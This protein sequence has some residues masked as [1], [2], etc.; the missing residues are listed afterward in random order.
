MAKVGIR[1]KKYSK[2][3]IQEALDLS[4]RSAANLLNKQDLRKKYFDKLE[5]RL[6]DTVIKEEKLESIR[7]MMAFVTDVGEKKYSGASSDCIVAISCA[8]SYLLASKGISRSKATSESDV[9]ASAVVKYVARNYKAELE[10]YSMWAEWKKPGIYPI[11][12]TVILDEKEEKSIE[13]LTKRYE[14]LISPSSAGKLAKKVGDVVPDKIKNMLED[15]GHAIQNTDLYEKVISLAA[16][17]FDILIKNSAKVSISERDVV[18]QINSTLKDNRIFTLDDVCY[19]R[20]YDIA[21]LVNGFK[22]QNIFVAFAEGG[23]TGLLGL[24][25]IAAN[26][27]S[28]MFFF[29]R[30]VQSI[31]MFYGYDVKNSADELEIA[32]SVFMEAMDPKKGSGSEMG[33]MIA[34]VMTMSEAL[35]VK[36][37]VGKGWQAMAEHGGLTLL[38]TQIRALAHASAKKALAEAGKKGLEPK[39]F[40]G[41]LKA[42]GKK[43]TQDA[44]KKAATPAA[45]A[46]TALMD[47][48]TMSKVIEYADIFYNK[49]FLAEKQIRIELCENPE[50]AKDVEYEVIKN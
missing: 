39:L 45:A 47:V 20:S 16:D 48:S 3:D 18:K 33:D 19:A 27:V 23:A 49:R 42:L 4:K 9:D 50:L 28:S 6:T 30:S 35:V 26:L 21:K 41:I 15:A 8:V 14:K 7:S 29:Y 32:T 37:T 46:I 22:T 25:G 12:P 2:K 44:I 24:K 36:Q 5:K 11:V 10:D 34:K 40:E 31:A 43:L 1:T 17:G 13:T 38:I